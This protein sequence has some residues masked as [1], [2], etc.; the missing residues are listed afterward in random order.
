MLKILTYTIVMA[1][2]GLACIQFNGTGKNGGTNLTAT[3]LKMTATGRGTVESN[4]KNFC[5][6]C[7]GEK[8]DAFVD[9]KWKYGN[10][11]EDI[12]KGIK[13][14]YP[15]GGM[16]SFEA[17]FT[18]EE[19]YELSDY[20]L[21]GIKNLKRYNFDKV[22]ETTNLFVSENQN[23]KLDTVVRGLGSPWS[24]AFLPNGEM[25]VTEKTGQLYRV[26]NDRSLQLING[27]PQVT[28]DGQGGLMD[29]I[30]H[31][32]FKSNKRIYISYSAFKKDGSATVATTAIMS[33]TL[34]GEKLEGQKIIFEALPYSRT[35]HHYGS[36][37]VFGR[38][39]LLYFS[40]GERGNEKQNPQSLANDLGKIH[41][42]KDDGTIPANNPFVN[43][44]GAKPSIFTY[45]NRNPQGVTMNPS[46][47]AIWSNEHGPRG[48]DEINIVGAGKNYG[49]PAIS[50]GIN[51]DGKI[52]TDKTAMDGMEQP[53][54][55]WIPSIGPSGMAFVEGKRYKGWQ[56]DLLV[57]S[58]R[59]KY[60]NRCKMKDGKVVGE[61]L[62]LKNIGRL[63]DVRM[64][65][66]GYIYV[67]VE[68]PGY[69]FRLLPVSR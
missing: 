60:L 32:D 35:R 24:M 65:P 64:G 3:G 69:I 68:N 26:K 14:G 38:D 53:L 16:P 58:L 8:M 23:I 56:G 10:T 13:Q 61:E 25:L 19:I 62:L 6:G 54:L 49:W 18:N 46:T 30:L 40:V 52:I 29:V 44:P 1:A 4:Y 28:A 34:T 36:R 31:P 43:K 57:G 17:A 41:R 42:I 2:I 33:A 27:G 22:P 9:R 55:Y 45:G 12:F 5:S 20:I 66:G 47:G 51:Y 50:Y 48:G 39:G 11:K 15:D 59:F 67:S 37:M 63:R 21:T 7:H